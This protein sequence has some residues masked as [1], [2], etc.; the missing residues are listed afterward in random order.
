M[1]PRPRRP[2]TAGKTVFVTQVVERRTPVF[3]KEIYCNLLLTNIRESKLRY[4]FAMHGYCILPDHLH[5]MVDLAETTTISA[6]M[7]SIK[8]NFT[9]SYKREIG[10]QGAMTF[11]QKGFYDR[12]IRDQDDWNDHLDY[13]HLNAVRHGFVL[14]PEEWRWSSFL[15]WKKRDGYADGWGWGSGDTLTAI[16]NGVE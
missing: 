16:A 14:R 8:R 13:I 12:V 5:L 9:H 10:V 6:L 7:H 3:R 15:E 11:W 2:Q 4:P 1:S